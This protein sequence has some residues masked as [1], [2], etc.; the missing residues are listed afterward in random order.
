MNL[1]DLNPARVLER[2]RPR[3]RQSSMLPAL[4]HEAPGSAI[5]TGV[6]R[7][8]P[9][10]IHIYDFTPER[11]DEAD[12]VTIDQ[13]AA[14]RARS[15]IT[16]IDVNGIHDAE[17]I[18]ALCKRF[19]IHA[20]SIEDILNPSHRAK[21]EYFE[22]YVY[23]VFK[24]VHLGPDDCDQVKTTYEQVSLI[25]GKEVVLTFQETEQDVFDGV[26]K[27][28]RGPESRIRK[29]G[30]DYLAYS[31][32]DAIVDSYLAVLEH[33]AARV[34]AFEV[35]PIRELSLSAPPELHVLKREL[36]TFRKAVWPLREAVASL[37]RD[38]EERI[39]ADTRPFLRD[40]HDHV[41]QIVESIDIYR[42]MVASLQD[43]FLTVVSNR[44]NQEMRLLTVIATIFIPLTFVA[45]VYGMNFEFMPE[46]KWHYGYAAVWGLMALVA[47]G[48]IFLFR[49]RRWL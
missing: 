46:L 26:R 18:E 49:R 23:L 20:L 17:R 21:I 29:R 5:Y 6:G 3:L 19:D 25:L 12:D 31:L 30:P 16:W 35:A 14:V 2:L 28:L 1:H 27:R 43:L 38:E 42:E 8:H 13:A 48:S 37:T 7:S 24:M 41:V 36:L 11:L 45:G 33:F 15:T 9:I 44:M 4:A 40:L 34:E 10:R 47:V 39:H 22:D 32:M